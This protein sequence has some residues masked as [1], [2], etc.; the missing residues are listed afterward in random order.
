M[1]HFT[2]LAPLLGRLGPGVVALLSVVVG[3][4]VLEEPAGLPP[5]APAHEPALPGE[6]VGVPVLHHLQPGPH[7]AAGQDRQAILRPHAERV[8]EGEAAEEGQVLGDVEEGGGGDGGGRGPL[9]KVQQE[10]AV[11]VQGVKVG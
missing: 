1:E 4:Q 8:A 11:Q 7:S 3:Q 2:L 9:G 10:A 5:L 6:G